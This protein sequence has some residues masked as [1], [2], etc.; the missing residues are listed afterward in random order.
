M[1]NNVILAIDGSVGS[2]RALAYARQR[3]ELQGASVIVAYIIEWSPFAFSTPEE[4][5]ER[6]A[7]RENEVARA[8]A[9]VV[10]P[11]VTYLKEAG[12]KVTSVVRHGSPAETLLRVAEEYEAAQIIIGRRGQSTIK[13]LLFGSV[14]ANLIQTATVPVVVVP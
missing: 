9:S 4:N 11:A 2:D 6:H 5:A 8:K 13:S 7:R 10:A 3:A 14:A 1:K 12:V